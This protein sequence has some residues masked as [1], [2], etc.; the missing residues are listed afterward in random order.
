MFER[1]IQIWSKVL[2]KKSN[3]AMYQ[4]Y[5]SQKQDAGAGAQTAE[6]LVI[7]TLTVCLFSFVVG[8]HKMKYSDF[9]NFKQKAMHT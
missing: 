5:L 8:E 1:E 2:L 9:E 7:P 3:H 6:P 4:A